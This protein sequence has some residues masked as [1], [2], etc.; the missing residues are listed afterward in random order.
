MT[1]KTTPFDPDMAVH[2]WHSPEARKEGRLPHFTWCADGT[3][4][5]REESMPSEWW[6][7]RPPQHSGDDSEAAALEQE[8]EACM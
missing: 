2:F 6:G 1:N 5:E 4:R 8:E 3:T 7:R